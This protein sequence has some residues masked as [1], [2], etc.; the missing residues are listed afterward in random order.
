MTNKF[1]VFKTGVSVPSPSQYCLL[2]PGSPRAVCRC[3]ERDRPQCALST[4]AWQPDRAWSRQGLVRLSL[5]SDGRCS[6]SL[7]VGLCLIKVRRPPPHCWSP[8]VV[9]DRGN[10]MMPFVH[11]P[12]ETG[13]LSTV[14][15]VGG[16]GGGVFRGGG[17]EQGSQGSVQWE[18]GGLCIVGA[19]WSLPPFFTSSRSDL[20]SPHSAESRSLGP[21]PAKAQTLPAA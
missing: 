16:G 19:R 12:D 20:Q 10:V 3:R 17:R 15:M 7:E 21:E 11:A 13:A 14:P 1:F 6:L 2:Q 8:L 18:P 9:A 5:G 4:W